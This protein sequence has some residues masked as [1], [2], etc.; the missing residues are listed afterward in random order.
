MYTRIVDSVSQSAG[1][2]LRPLQRP[3]G[4]FAANA[5]SAAADNIYTSALV[6]SLFNCRCHACARLQAER[7]I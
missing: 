2:P 4:A 7:R 1:A 5:P 3:I 6:S